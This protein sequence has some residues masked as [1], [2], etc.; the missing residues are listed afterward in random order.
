VAAGTGGPGHRPDRQKRAQRAPDPLLVDAVFGLHRAADTAGAV[1]GPLPGL[2]LYAALGHRLRPLF[3]TAVIPAVAS[4]RLVRAVRDHRPIRPAA[5]A[6]GVRPGASY[7]APP[8]RYWRVLAVLTLF[9]LVNFPDALLL[10]AASWG[11]LSP[12]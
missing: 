2:A 12:G 8:A 4:V 7:R 6:R 11:C 1:A 10:R 9:G 5:G 3:W